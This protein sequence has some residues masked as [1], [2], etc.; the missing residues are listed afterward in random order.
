MIKVTNIPQ[1]TTAIMSKWP[2]KR[3]KSVRLTNITE[4]YSLNSEKKSDINNL[5]QK[6]LLY[7]QV[8]AWSYNGL[9]AAPLSD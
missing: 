6:H 9:S 1:Y 7:K 8:V 3:I 5:T 2:L 4:I